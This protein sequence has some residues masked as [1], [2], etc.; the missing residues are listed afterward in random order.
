MK[1]KDALEIIARLEER[2]ALTKALVGGRVYHCH[3]R[4][5]MESIK[6]ANGE[7]RRLR[8]MINNQELEDWIEVGDIE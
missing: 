2:I 8:E 1:V 6:S 3:Y 5:H 7:I 4:L